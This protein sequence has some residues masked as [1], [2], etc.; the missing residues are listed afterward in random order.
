MSLNLDKY[1]KQDE[2]LKDKSKNFESIAKKPTGLKIY[3]LPVDIQELKGDTVSLARN[4]NWIK[5]L[6]KDIYLK[7]A[8]KTITLMNDTK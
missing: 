6:S 1:K 7:E 8:V 2:E 4:N 5:D 3:S